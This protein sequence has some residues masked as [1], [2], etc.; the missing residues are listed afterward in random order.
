MH[1]EAGKY[2]RGRSVPRPYTYAGG[3]TTKDECSRVCRI[4]E[5]EKQSNLT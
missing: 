5:G 4:S 2:N 3:N 1:L